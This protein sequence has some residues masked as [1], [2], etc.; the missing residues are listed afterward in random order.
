MELSKLPKTAIRKK[1]RLG[2]GY[3]SGK[4]GHT[5]GRGAKGLKARGKLPLTFDGTKIKKSFLKRLPLQRGKGKFKSLKPGPVVVNLK[6]LNLLPKGSEVDIKTL[7]KQ[8][9]VEEKEAKKYGVKILG[10]GEL[11][12]SLK[13]KLPC[14]KGA[15]KKIEKVGGKVIAVEKKRLKKAKPV[16]KPIVKKTKKTKSKKK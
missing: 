16:K 11:K 3:G 1:K 7:V 15:I 2:R 4:G 9:I 5:V 14:S 8:R 6:Y 13:V 12:V 10:D